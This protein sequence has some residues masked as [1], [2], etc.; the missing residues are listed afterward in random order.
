MLWFWV[1][2][3][4]LVRFDGKVF[5][6]YGCGVLVDLLFLFFALLRL[7]GVFCWVLL[8]IWLSFRFWGLFDYDV[9]VLFI[10]F[11]CFGV[12][13]RIGWLFWLFVYV[14]CVVLLG[15][16]FCVLCLLRVGG[17]IVSLLAGRLFSWCLLFECFVLLCAVLNWCL[18]LFY[19]WVNEFAGDCCVGLHDCSVVIIILLRCCV[20]VLMV[21]SCCFLF[22]LT[23]GWLVLRVV[24]FVL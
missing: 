12:L 9:W 10:V 15:L 21:L 22:C 11:A 5:C 6:T 3:G 1:D 2:S 17:F 20:V 14:A 4:L 8:I 23:F 16:G 18:G 24:Y 7:A 13:I 19:R